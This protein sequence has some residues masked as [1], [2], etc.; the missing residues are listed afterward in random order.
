MVELTDALKARIANVENRGKAR[1]GDSGWTD[2]ME[3]LSRVG[4]NADVMAQI[5]TRADAIEQIDH[6]ARE[7]MLTLAGHEDRGVAR[8]AEEA[9]SRARQEQKKAWLAS[10]ARTR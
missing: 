4:V 9:Y 2:R 8:S 10:K 1:F 7:A 3:S 6:A 5:V